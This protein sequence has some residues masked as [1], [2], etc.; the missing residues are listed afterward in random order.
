MFHPERAGHGDSPAFASAVVA[1]AASCRMVADSMSVPLWKFLRFAT[2]ALG[3]SAVPRAFAAEPASS[4]QQKIVPVLKEHCFKCHNAE[5]QKG[6]IDLTKFATEGDVL[7][8]YKLWRRVIEQIETQEM[9]PDDDKFT[10]M[11]GSMILTGVKQ[12]LALLDS[13]HP[14]LLDPGPSLV[15][16]L[17]RVEFNNALRD[18]TG[19][20]VDFSQQVGMPEDSTGSSFENVAAA[21]T[22]PSALLEKYL[23]AADIALDKLFYDTDSAFAAKPDWERKQIAEKLKK[24]R[25]KFFGDLAE[26]PD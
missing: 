26:Q 14:A 16:R 7:K 21:L 5:K 1:T 18:L 20:D 2:L 8:K 9:P 4:F 25:A 6:G 15:R 17:S 22:M 19:L 23:A 3:V 24:P 12:T 11:H 13:G 10:A